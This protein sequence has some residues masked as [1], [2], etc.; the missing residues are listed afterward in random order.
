M[1]ISQSE[2]LSEQEANTAQPEEGPTW[3]AE[4]E[5][6]PKGLIGL[7]PLY[8]TAAA[9]ADLAI[10][11]EERFRKIS[12]QNLP[13]EAL[14]FT[15][16]LLAPVRPLL[17][18]D[19]V[20]MRRMLRQML[21][22]HGQVDVHSSLPDVAAALSRP[23]AT[24]AQLE[25]LQ[26]VTD[27]LGL[28]GEEAPVELFIDFI[29]RHS[30]PS[31]E[32]NRQH[33]KQAAKTIQSLQKWLFAKKEDR[34]QWIHQQLSHPR[35]RHEYGVPTSAFRE[36]IFSW[37]LELAHSGLAKMCY[38]TELGGQNDIEGFL[39]CIETLASFDM[40]LSIKF[41]VNFGL[42][43]GSVY[44][45]GSDY[46]HQKFLL[47]A[48]DCKLPG[49]FAMTETGHGSNVRGLA[50]TAHYDRQSDEFVVHTPHDSARKD[51]IGNVALHAKMATVFAQLIIDSENYGVHAFLV[52][53]RDEHHQ[54]MSG[55]TIEDCGEKVG[56]NGIDNGRLYF[57]QVRIPR[58]NLLNRFAEVTAQGV[59]SSPIANPTKRF[60]TM[61]STLV[62]GRATLAG[63]SL[64][65][66]KV[67][68]ANALRYSAE[69]RQFG[70]EGRP[71]SVVLDYQTHQRR[72]IPRLA[73]TL[74]LECTIRKIYPMC[75]ESVHD[76]SVR[77]RLDNLASGLK[78]WATWHALET[79][80][81]C[82]ECCGGQGYLAVNRFGQLKADLDVFTTFEGDN[83]VL[84]QQVTKGLLTNYKHQ[85]SE[86]RFLGLIRHFT[87]QAASSVIEWNP[88][89]T[90]NT[91]PEHL[92]DPEFHKRAMRARESH[93]LST[94]ARRLRHKVEAGGKPWD[95]AMSCQDHM[96]ALGHAHIERVLVEN[97]C[98]TTANAPKE[99]QDA[100]ALQRDIFALSV[101][102][103][104]KGWFLEN[105]Y[106]EGGKAKAIRSLCLQLCQQAREVALLWIDAFDLPLQSLSAPIATQAYPIPPVAAASGE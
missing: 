11:L 27:L 44:H 66:S 39:T 15:K 32:K 7:F 58:T 14:E 35:F 38:P 9:E 37:V 85:F 99:I 34:R 30:Q 55:V 13:P 63:A 86:L 54:P 88:F 59:Y 51:Y 73:A 82:R 52:P 23:Q 96:V 10:N 53:I 77:A 68:L 40:S 98:E 5:R 64:G 69:R 6:L 105:G 67:A 16:T 92:R 18:R 87:T 8:Y 65:V 3:Q 93:L 12:E 20:V 84:M 24:P 91:D 19:F 101:L 103:R 49:C 50:T 95:A 36:R 72:L 79:V 60:F 29:P 106:F 46:H 94:L 31:N 17:A 4:L 47:P 81:V 71:E 26:T 90:R 70:E 45:L 1:R 62:M 104:D 97:F 42:F 21:A 22:G 33:E 83:T 48:L 102:E 56:L 57:N 74:A 25:L 43:A 76:E 100:L 78:A 80:Q 75:A 61:I 89:V 41:G 2:P 28:K